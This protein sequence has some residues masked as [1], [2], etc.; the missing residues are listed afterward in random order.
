MPVFSEGSKH[1]SRPAPAC[2]RTTIFSGSRLRPRCWRI[3]K[4]AVFSVLAFYLIELIGI[5]MF[6]DNLLY[7]PRRA[8]DWPHSSIHRYLRLGLLNPDWAS[9]ARDEGGFGE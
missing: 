4:L 9:A 1:G 6:Q 5:S 2:R 7:Y 8:V 3:P